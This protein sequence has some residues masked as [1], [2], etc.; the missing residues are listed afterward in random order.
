MA[1]WRNLLQTTGLCYR[2]Q[3]PLFVMLKIGPVC[4][5]LVGLMASRPADKQVV[6]LEIFK[7]R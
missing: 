4:L 5:V 2:Q 3:A 1:R 6:V 7:I